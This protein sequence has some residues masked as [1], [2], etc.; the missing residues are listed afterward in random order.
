MGTRMVVSF[1]RERKTVRKFSVQLEV[2][3]DDTWC[4]VIRYD[5]AHGKPHRHTFYPD[6]SEITP[7]LSEGIY[8]NLIK[9]DYNGR[10]MTMSEEFYKK[11][12]D[13]GLEF[14]NYFFSHLDELADQIPNRAYVVINIKGDEDFNRQRLALIENPRR[15]T[16]VLAEKSGKRWTIRPLY[17]K[18]SRLKAT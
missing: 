18:S 11:N 8:S 13:L 14:D 6:G 10:A 9:N 4:K 2:R 16:I 17:P 15:K 7:S 5:N 3:L 12:S 1:E